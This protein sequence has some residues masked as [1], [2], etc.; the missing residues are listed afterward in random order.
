MV[1]ALEVL[2]SALLLA[3]AVVALSVAVGLYANRIASRI[4]EKRGKHRDDD[5][6]MSRPPE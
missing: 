4:A 2:G 3:V 5:G 6:S 1:L